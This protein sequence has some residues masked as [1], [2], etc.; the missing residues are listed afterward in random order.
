VNTID[1]TKHKTKPPKCIFVL[2]SHV[3]LYHQSLL[4]FMILKSQ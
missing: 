2:L 4:Y 1:Q 3:R